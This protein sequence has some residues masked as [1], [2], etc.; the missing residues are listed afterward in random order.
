MSG[1]FFKFSFI[2]CES[3]VLKNA[4]KNAAQTRIEFVRH[5]FSIT[6]FCLAINRHSRPLPCGRYSHVMLAKD[7]GHTLARLVGNRA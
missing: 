1:K 5:S 3:Y 4:K 2:F 6:V 7:E